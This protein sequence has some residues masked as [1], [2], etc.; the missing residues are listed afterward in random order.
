MY[1]CIPLSSAFSVPFLLYLL[2]TDR[3]MNR[4]DRNEASTSD[5]IGRDLYIEAIHYNISN[6]L[7]QF[8]VY[9]LRGFDCADR[10]ERQLHLLDA[11]PS[12]NFD[13]P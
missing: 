10:S 13:I 4:N 1:S 12:H 3:A 9:Q 11:L 5:Q 2:D 8:L 6:V 7:K